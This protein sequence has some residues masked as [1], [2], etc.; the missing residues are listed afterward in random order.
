M[1]AAKEREAI[2]ETRAAAWRARERQS[3]A[4][5]LAADQEDLPADDNDIY[6][7]PPPSSR[8][9]GR[10]TRKTSK[11]VSQEDQ[12]QMAEAA[13]GKKAKKPA[14]RKQRVR[15]VSQFEDLLN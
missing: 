10:A 7:M 12:N 5:A 14:L 13:K 8:R 3:L 6:E 4:E 2:A 11:L 15:E 1:S 9:S